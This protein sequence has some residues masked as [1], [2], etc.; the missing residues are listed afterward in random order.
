MNGNEVD[1]GKWGS[2]V[3]VLNPGE[4]G[5]C[6]LLCS[7][8]GTVILFCDRLCLIQKTYYWKHKS[9]KQKITM[10][11]SPYAGREATLRFCFVLFFSWQNL[12]VTVIGLNPGNLYKLRLKGEWM[13][14]FHKKI[15][16]QTGSAILFTY[17]VC[18][19]TFKVLSFT[20]SNIGQKYSRKMSATKNTYFFLCCEQWVFRPLKYLQLKLPV[21]WEVAASSQVPESLS[22]YFKNHS[23]QRVFSFNFVSP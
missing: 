10:N 12:P 19:H 4:L 8:I 23:E 7:S 15:L 20:T 14:W 16:K 21:F 5:G 17:T 9:S 13:H 11:I 3:C 2:R 1:E 6:D 22:N 18:L